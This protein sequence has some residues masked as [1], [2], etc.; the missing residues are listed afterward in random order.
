MRASLNCLE[1]SRPIPQPHHRPTPHEL[2]TLT[3]EGK[4]RRT[5]LAALRLFRDQILTQTPDEIESGEWC[6]LEEADALIA[7]LETDA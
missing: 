1:R 6:S 4:A 2:T 7:Q 5:I 3:P